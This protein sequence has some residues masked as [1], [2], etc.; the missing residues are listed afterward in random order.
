[1]SQ[2][3]IVNFVSVFSSSQKFKF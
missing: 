2:L 1:M 3:K